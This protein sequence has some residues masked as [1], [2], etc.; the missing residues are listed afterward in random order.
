M[1]RPYLLNT[2]QQNRLSTFSVSDLTVRYKLLQC[3]ASLLIIKNNHITCTIC[4]ETG[5][6]EKL[7]NALYFASLNVHIL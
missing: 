1:R 4:K 2:I 3:I 6:I 7:M 5:K